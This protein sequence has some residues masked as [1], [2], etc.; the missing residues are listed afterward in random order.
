MLTG[1]T[2]GGSGGGGGVRRVRLEARRDPFAL[3]TAPPTDPAVTASSAVTAAATAAA[4]APS[5]TESLWERDPSGGGR[6]RLLPGGGASKLSSSATAAPVAALPAA[7]ASSD[8]AT[9]PPTSAADVAAPPPL[10][11]SGLDVLFHLTAVPKRDGNRST[12][13]N[14]EWKMALE[15]VQQTSAA[16]EPG[17]HMAR[18]GVVWCATYSGG[19]KG[20]N[21]HFWFLMPEAGEVMNWYRKGSGEWSKYK[22]PPEKVGN[23]WR[24]SEW[25]AMN[26]TAYEQRVVADGEVAAEGIMVPPDEDM[27]DGDPPAEYKGLPRRKADDVGALAADEQVKWLA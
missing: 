18:N 12:S 17:M 16:L 15:L 9:V 27:R 25:G 7:D 6:L 14:C 5:G 20:T 22:A 21:G 23:W 19:A 2:P 10:A 3:S 26:D 8:A 4:A 1:V 11:V 13:C 24:S